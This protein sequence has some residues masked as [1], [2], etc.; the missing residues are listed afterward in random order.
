MCRNFLAT[1]KKEVAVQ[2]TKEEEA[3][4][5]SGKSIPENQTDQKKRE[6]RRDDDDD[7]QS[8]KRRKH[9]GKLVCESRRPKVR[10]WKV[11]RA[12]QPGAKSGATERAR[13]SEREG[14]RKKGKL[15]FGKNAA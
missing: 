9:G 12:T 13:A 7:R 15:S 3:K 4:S 1:K 8:G 10:K 5:F 6:V 14:R 11:V 2:A